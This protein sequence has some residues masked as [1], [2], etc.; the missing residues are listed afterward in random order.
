MAWDLGFH[1]YVAAGGGDLSA[2]P[3]ETFRPSGGGLSDSAVGVVEL[4]AQPSESFTALSDSA[5]GVVE[6]WTRPSETFTGLITDTVAAYITPLLA[7]PSETFTGLISDD[8]GTPE[9]SDAFTAT[10]SETFASGNGRIRDSVAAYITPLLAEPSESFTALSDVAVGVVELWT[11]PSETFAGLIS[12]D[13]GTPS[14]PSGNDLSVPDAAESLTLS[15]GGL[16]NFVGPLT[17]SDTVTPDL[18]DPLTLTPY[19]S[20]VEQFTGLGDARPP[21]A[22]YPPQLQTS[23]PTETITLTTSGSVEHVKP[24]LLS[25]VVV[26]DRID[27][28]VFE[29]VVAETFG[30]LHDHTPAQFVGGADDLGTYAEDALTVSARGSVE[31]VKPLMLSDVVTDVEIVFDTGEPGWA[32]PVTDQM[33]AISDGVIGEVGTFGI[34]ITDTPRAVLDA[35]NATATEAFTGI[36]DV[37]VGGYVLIM[38][39]T[40]WIYPSDAVAGPPGETELEVPDAAESFTAISDAPV[41]SDALP[42]VAWADWYHLSD[43]PSVTID[44]RLTVTE[45]FS[46]LTDTV[47][48]ALTPLPLEVS[49]TFAGLISDAVNANTGLVEFTPAETV[50]AIT[51]SVTATRFEAATVPPERTW[52]VRAETRVWRVVA[53]DRVWRVPAQT[54]IWRVGEE[55]RVWRVP[56]EDGDWEV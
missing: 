4:W 48:P 49:E 24:L 22:D 43:V 41:T 16:V 7:E 8:P 34:Q 13:P 35:F 55:D 37:G 46:L 25:D 12:D 33:N 9:L 56:P 26:A 2:T 19:P 27:P 30:A 14:I 53:E 40:E 20:P 10:P 50:T 31:H 3:S 21:I 17:I 1:E 42:P 38:Q 18:V 28:D 39:W 52:I 5:V 47:G 51:D 45:S 36:T 44:L 23:D 6:L 29:A 11:R 54:R 15:D 32:Q